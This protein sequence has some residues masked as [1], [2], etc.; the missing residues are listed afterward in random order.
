[1]KKTAIIFAADDNYAIGVAISIMSIEDKSPTLADKYIIYYANWN[2]KQIEYVRN[3]SPKVNMINFELNN[4][5]NKYPDLINNIEAKKFIERYTHFKIAF[6]EYWENLKEYDQIIFLDADLVIIDDITPLKEVD[7]LGWRCG[8]A[9]FKY[10]DK[11][12]NRPNGGVII[13]N[14]DL[15]INKMKTIYINHLLIENNDEIAL[16]KMAYD[17]NIKITEIP[18]EYNI[19]SHALDKFKISN[20]IKIFHCIGDKKIWNYKLYQYIFPEYNIYI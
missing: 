1:M 9:K 11:I 6:Y 10:N 2:E 14:N 16:A 15:P 17:L 12:I 3:L 18:A 8:L 7:S 4:F 20:D 5:K 19:G 13:F